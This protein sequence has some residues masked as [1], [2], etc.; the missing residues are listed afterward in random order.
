MTIADRIRQKRTELN[1]SQSELAQRANYYDKT[2][3]SKIEHSGNDI[4]MKQVKRVAKALGVS[5]EFLMGWEN[6]VI[7]PAL[8]PESE[9]LSRAKLYYEAYLNSSP[10]IQSAID[11]LTKVTQN[12]K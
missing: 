5:M 4:S 6:E 1:M 9:F 7:Q 8:D 12:K 2:S 3:I 10:E 11:S